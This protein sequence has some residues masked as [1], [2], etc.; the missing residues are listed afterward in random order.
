[1]NTAAATNIVLRPTF[2]THLECSKTGTTVPSDTLHNLS[3][4]GWPL[5]VRY[6]LGAIK[7]VL[8]RDDLESRPSDLWR[9]RELLPVRHRHNIV[10]LGELATPLIVARRLMA[11]LNA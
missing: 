3:P 1:M 8:D 2:V 9:Y 6:D 11:E 5:L 7:Q 4:D 10:T